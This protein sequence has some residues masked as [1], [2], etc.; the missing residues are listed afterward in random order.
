M[1]LTDVL[2]IAARRRATA[3]AAVTTADVVA[4]RGRQRPGA[5]GRRSARE[6]NRRVLTGWMRAGVTV[7]DPATHVG[8][9]RR[10]SSS[11]TSRCCPGTQLHGATRV[12]GGADV[13]PDTTLTD[14]E[15][16]AGAGVVRTHGSGAA[17]GAGATRRAVRLPAAGH[18]ARRAGQDRHVR[19][20]E[21]R[22]RSATGSK[23][24]HLSYVGD[25]DDRRGHQHRRGH[26]LRQLRRRRTSTAPSSATTSG[27]A[28]TTCSSPRSTIGDGAYTAAG[29]VI[30]RRRAARRDGRGTGAA[31]QRRGLGGAPPRRHRRG[32][33]GRAG[34]GQR[35]G[36]ERRQG[37]AGE[38]RAMTGITS[39]SEKRLMLFTGRAHPELAD[40]V[41]EALGV[42]L[43]ADRRL[44]LRQRRDLRAVRGV[45]ARL[46]RVRHP[47]PHGADQ[48]VD[49]GAADHGR[50]AEAGLGQA[51]HRGRCRSTPTPGRTR[52]TAA[53]SRS[54]RG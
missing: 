4:D 23:V 53:A 22:R 21:E 29:S 26:R 43:V 6:L 25:A 51:D 2:G 50:R 52:S 40:E 11:P 30:T 44:R 16:G 27:S 24:P 19:R 1:Y 45:G 41:A 8:R 34:R 10:S 48:Q 33:G 13:G 12:A 15:V 5:A 37:R 35:A 42:D 7:V 18:G 32:R 39:T 20:D 3:S 17:I 47:E 36:H 9:R 49:H 46:R 31:A 54:R 14:T 38:G 28:A